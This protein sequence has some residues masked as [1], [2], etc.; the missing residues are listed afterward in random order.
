MSLENQ[1]PSTNVSCILKI[2]VVENY[3]QV[4]YI[5]SRLIVNKFQIMQTQEEP[6]NKE[7]M[8]YVVRH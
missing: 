8:Y 5:L 1:T 3:P 2:I 4:S 7:R 6:R